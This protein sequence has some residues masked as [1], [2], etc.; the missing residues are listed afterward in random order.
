MTYGINQGFTKKLCSIGLG[1]SFIF[2]SANLP[3]LALS[4]APNNGVNP[5]FF[6]IS[7]LIDESNS[8][9][10]ETEFEK[11]KNDVSELQQKLFALQIRKYISD[12][13]LS[14]NE[15]L[16]VKKDIEECLNFYNKNSQLRNSHFGYPANM[17][18]KSGLVDFFKSIE[19]DS[20]LAN[21]CGDINETGNYQMDSKKIERDILKLFAQKFGLDDKYWGYITSGGSESNE[22]AIKASF[23]KNPDGILYFCESAHYS[24]YKNSEFFEKRV[25]PQISDEDESIDCSILLKEIEENYRKYKR[26]ANIILTWGTTKY[27]SCDDVKRITEF[28]REKEIP[29]Y[30]HVDAALFGGIPNNQV[31]AP[32]ISNIGALHIDSISVSLHKYI[33]VPIVKSVLLSVS[34]PPGS[35]IDYIGQTDSTTSGSRDIM[36]FSIKQQIIDVLNYSNPEDYIRNVKFFQKLL[37]EKNIKFIKNEKSNTFVIDAPSE[38]ICKKYQLS[39]F[40]DKNGQDKAHI[41]IFPYQSQ[42]VMRELVDAL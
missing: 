3:L 20:F 31:E 25:I 18:L 33:G 19:K 12:L 5:A 30:L 2:N 28:L 41:I 32:I 6:K 1:A 10:S 21:N 11:L 39:C 29:Y 4:T 42:S 8:K 17:P 36:P 35:Y 22:W 24:I 40:K 34:N 13:K 16:N 14:E 7:E 27:G 37:V 23:K 9:V 15:I 26:P 38:D